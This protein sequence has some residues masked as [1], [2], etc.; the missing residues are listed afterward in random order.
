MFQ[1]VGETSCY[2]NGKTEYLSFDN[3]NHDLSIV[4]YFHTHSCE[5]RNID[6]L[7][8]LH[9][10]TELNIGNNN[11]TDISVLS[12]LTKLDTLF[13]GENPVSDVRALSKLKCLD[14]LSISY[15]KVT[16]ISPLVELTNIK[17]LYMSRCKISDY[18]VLE[19]MNVMRLGVDDNDD[20]SS[21]N[22]Y[23][24]GINVYDGFICYDYCPPFINYIKRL[25]KRDNNHLRMKILKL[26]LL[27]FEQKRDDS[28]YNRLS[29]LSYN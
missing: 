20:L 25:S 11:I 18:S 3:C 9:N 23:R 4:A 7:K 12:S 27:F 22:L 16:D 1:F 8:F 28:G 17:R 29:F 6:N 10:L 5:L 2:M 15:T 24:T 26:W 14:T 13:M 21:V 19:K